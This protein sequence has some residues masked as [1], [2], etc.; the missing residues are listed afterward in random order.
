MSQSPAEEAR[1]F[2]AA[3]PDV[4]QIEV[5]V[6]DASGAARGKILTREELEGAFSD[7]R[8]LP[9]S[10]FGLDI[11]GVDVEEAGLLWEDGDK[12]RV[13]W[14]VPGTL[15]RAPWRKT[16]GGI[17][18]MTAHERDRTP[19]HADP[20]QALTRVVDRF[21]DL[22]LTPVAAIELE[23][24]LVDR[25]SA[26]GGRPTPP[27]SPEGWA[28]T[29]L[30]ACSL[31]DLS[32][33]AP[34]LDDIYAG[35]E[36]MGLPARTLIA[37]YAPGQLEIVLKHRADA[38][39]AADD[40]VLFKRLVKGTAEKHGYA[41]TFMAKP[42]AEHTGSGMHVHASLADSDGTNIFA[43]DE[44][45][46]T[47]PLLHAIGGQLATM[48]E[49]MA[50]FAPNANS[51]RRFRMGSYAPVGPGWAIDNRTVPLRVTAGK[52][53]TRHFEHRVAGADAN[54]YLALATVLA[55][56]HKGL[57]EKTDPGVPITGNGYEQIEPDFPQGW[58]A[59]IEEVANSAFL[60]DYL[61]AEFMAV[62]SAIKRAE[63][64]RFNALVSDIDH[65]W[66]LRMA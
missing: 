28:Q 6:T 61:G 38:M 31:D 48:R 25:A 50:I 2:L 32:D 65:A 41:A 43:G 34:L 40:A 47:G 27:T 24:F 14:P 63:A 3:N 55:G 26:Q 18:L 16:P 8:P 44:P 53:E 49:S 19:F 46:P 33:F 22:N 15:T 58:A 10:I 4:R 51:W 1:Q 5:I 42:F 30:Q 7:G 60:A 59:A 57:T 62:F 13:L 36:I 66:Y 12:D 29:H 20:R 54:P 21:A 11:T 52:P 35:A 9:G 45:V 17:V 39:R 56:V 37:E 64:D 23:F